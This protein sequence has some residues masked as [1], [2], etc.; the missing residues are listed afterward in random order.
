MKLRRFLPL[1][2]AGLTLALPGLPARASSHREAPMI[3]EDPM[4]DNTDTY[5]FVSP[6][7]RNKVVILA[8]YIPLEE[9]SGGPSYYYFSDRVLYRINVDRN[10]DGREDVIFEFRF[11]TTV[12]TPGTILPYLGPITQLTRDGKTVATAANINPNYNRYQTYTLTMIEPRGRLKPRTTVLARDVIVP[13]NNAGSS[14]TPDF[15][16]LTHQAIHTVP[17]AS[18]RTFAGQVDDPFFLDLGAIFDLLRVRPFRSLHVLNS[19]IPLPDR[20]AAPDMLSGFNCHTIAMEVPITFLTKTAAIPGGTDPKRVLG[21][22]ASAYR[23]RISVL[24]NGR[25]SGKSSFVQVSRLGA[26]LVNELFIPISDPQGRTR[27]AWNM[28]DPDHDAKFKPFFQRPE[29]ALRLAELYPVLRPVIPNVTV[30]PSTNKGAFTGDRSDLL[31]GV[32]PL[33]NFAPDLLRLDVSVGPSANPNRLGVIGGDP[34]GFPNGRRLADDVV[35]IYMRAA[36]G[37]LFPGNVTVGQFTGT[38]GAFL[39]AINF[40]DGVDSNENGR[41]AFQNAFPFAAVAH[42]GVNPAHIGFD[43]PEKEAMPR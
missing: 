19:A 9:P 12:Q 31:G 34:G 5:F 7:D 14:T 23:Q 8:N 29:P 39:S 22:Y 6:E 37:V 40:G 2:A 27:D 13:P 24:R 21:V 32:T 41:V 33:L 25:V 42:N 11:H 1:L 35:D 30:N 3:S 43:D 17:G 36:A 20:P 15:A 16:A 28:T 4:A 10:N 38:R 18:I 26:P